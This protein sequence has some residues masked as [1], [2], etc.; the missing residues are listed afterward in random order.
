[1]KK[2]I[3]GFIFILLTSCQQVLPNVPQ[4]E[5][6][7]NNDAAS[8]NILL[9][10]AV[11]GDAEAQFSLSN[12][13][14]PNIGLLSK[15]EAIKT[16]TNIQA[17]W[18]RKS[19]YSGRKDALEALAHEYLVGKSQTPIVGSSGIPKDYELYMCFH[20]SGLGEK[21]IADCQ[22]M[23]MSKGYIFNLNPGTD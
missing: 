8:Y 13:I 2:I 7:A 18:L 17:I 14:D 20:R 9:L 4:T 22:Q 6:K 23:E 3:L 5:T 21:K 10:K 15:E 16:T 11:N 1:M 12:L 19:A